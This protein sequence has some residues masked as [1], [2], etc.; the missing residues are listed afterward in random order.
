MGTYAGSTILGMGD[1]KHFILVRLIIMIINIITISVLANNNGITSTRNI[2]PN[3]MSNKC[4]D[5]HDF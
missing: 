3:V 5:D 2:L 4:H 1:S